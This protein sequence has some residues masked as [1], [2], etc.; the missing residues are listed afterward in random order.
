MRVDLRCMVG[1]GCVA[2]A[3]GML[4]AVGHD[5]K[6]GDVLTAIELDGGRV[7]IDVATP[8]D[9]DGLVVAGDRLVM[10]NRE[11]PPGL[12][13]LRPDGSDEQPIERRRA[14]QVKLSAGRLLA[15]L[16]DDAGDT[17]FVQARDAATM[18]ELW[19]APAH[20]PA[21]G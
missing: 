17:R 1:E 3:V 7:K 6:T 19:S 18:R 5:P 9:A 20:G 14:H 2:V 15:T 10:L 13:S 21:C 16:A 4:F 8:H 11:G 12:Y